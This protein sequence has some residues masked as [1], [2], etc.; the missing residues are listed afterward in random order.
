M[1]TPSH[2]IELVRVDEAVLGALIT[3]AIADA[4]PDDVT[5]PLGDGWTPDRVAWLCTYHRERR[6]G[7]TGGGD[8]ETSAIRF[9]GRIVGASRLHR[10]NPEDASELE[11]GIWLV[12]SVRGLGIGRSVVRLAAERA[13][14]AG[15]TRLLARTTNGNGA[16]LGMLQRANAEIHPGP[17]G[18]V[19]AVLELIDFSGQDVS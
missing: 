7:F 19:F 5:P 13:A 11:C 3:V 1:R 16:A 2:D 8:E 4:E 17:E 15:A 12:K 6:S 14:R 9:D 10:V 18:A